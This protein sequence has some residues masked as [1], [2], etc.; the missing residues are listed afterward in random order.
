MQMLP[1][2]PDI[3]E[4]VAWDGFLA[5]SIPYSLDKK[6]LKNF[7]SCIIIINTLLWIISPFSVFFVYV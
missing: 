7:K 5:Q 6:N 1:F 3:K 2:S 4:T